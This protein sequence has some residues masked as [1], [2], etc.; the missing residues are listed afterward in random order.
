MTKKSRTS[1]RDTARAS[2]AAPQGGGIPGGSLFSDE[3]LA[4]EPA[5]GLDLV[6]GADHRRAGEREPAATD[7]GAGA[8]EQL[9]IP[10]FDDARVMYPRIGIA[11]Y[12]LE[13]GGVVTLEVHSEGEVYTF[14][15]GSAEEALA[16]AFPVAP[17]EEPA[18]AADIF[19]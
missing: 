9:I 2:A 16:V 12:A 1:S 15:A 7:P 3:P 14:Q 19:G 8:D 4:D 13:P 17:V 11:L 18:S 10:T 5:R 6:D